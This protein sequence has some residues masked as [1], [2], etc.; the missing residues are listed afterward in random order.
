MT[1]PI[2]RTVIYG[3]DRRPTHAHC[4]TIRTYVG[5]PKEKDSAAYDVER[6]V[7]KVGV[8]TYRLTEKA[9]S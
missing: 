7:S 8:T 9:G 4:S 3:W 6:D 5:V 2:I 1:K